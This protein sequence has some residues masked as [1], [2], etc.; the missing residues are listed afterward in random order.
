MAA[1]AEIS[2]S[3]RQELMT[4]IEGCARCRKMFADMKDIHATWLPERKGFE[5]HRSTGAES[6]LRHL[7]L[8]GVA[9]E[10]AQ[11]SIEAES[12]AY[13]AA[14][15]VR[16]FIRLH[17]LLA[18][19]AAVLILAVGVGLFGRIGAR[20][21]RSE[22]FTKAQ[23]TIDDTQRSSVSDTGAEL[24]DLRKNAHS[25]QLTQE[26]LETELKE[27]QADRHRLEQQ[28]DEAEERESA[29]QQ[30]NTASIQEISNLQ[31][32]LDAVRADQ[33][34]TVGELATLK[35]SMSERQ[36]EL[37]L[38][39]RENADMRDRLSQQ[40]AGVDRE[41]EL[42]ADGREIRDLIAARNLHII[43][44]Y[45][46]SGEG[47]TQKSFG[48]VFYTEGKSLVFYAYD[49]PARRPPTKYAFCAWGKKDGS[50]EV[51]VRN[52]GIFYN[53]DQTQ[54]RWVLKITDPQA[55]SEIDSVFVTLEKT[56]SGVENAPTG[57]K[58]LSAYLGSPAN[59]P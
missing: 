35:T 15:Q 26:K 3:E 10:G 46:T 9:T 30:S 40:T 51:K 16:P 43:D 41:R 27:T 25:A 49:L 8:Q 24:G 42:M 47:Q 33:S 38:V 50:G 23:S 1:A 7:I 5:I 34:N 11:F 52:L 21:S 59:H 57:K 31:Q 6:Q 22:L 56:D 53:D 18:A 44:V 20:R 45:D 14:H 37:A 13:P 2:A 12:V 17:R 32:Q 19:A 58:L 4:H 54:K 48:R 29:L 28:L 36:T 55:L 39:E